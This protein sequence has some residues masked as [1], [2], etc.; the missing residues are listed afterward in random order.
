MCP[1][2]SSSGR[3]PA[4]SPSGRPAC[5]PSGASAGASGDA[6]AFRSG[7][8]VAGPPSDPSRRP[9]SSCRQA[10]CRDAAERVAPGS[11]QSRVAAFS[12]I[13]A[14]LLLTA[15]GIPTDDEPRAIDDDE[16]LI[17]ADVPSGPAAAGADRIFLVAP[18]EQGLLRSVPRDAGS[19]EDLIEVLLLGANDTELADQWRSQIPSNTTL[20]SMYTQGTTLHLDFSAALTSLSAAVQPQALAQ[21]VYTAAEVDG[22]TDVSITI[23]GQQQP[24]PKGNGDSTTDPLRTYDYPGLVQTAQPAYPAQALQ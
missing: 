22:I 18:G 11:R 7:G 19:T 8:P 12:T 24:L 1:P 3:A 6:A 4:G 15:C 20:R 5:P 17:G 16:P 9:S 23:D 13:A 14:A 2:S 10:A 21:I